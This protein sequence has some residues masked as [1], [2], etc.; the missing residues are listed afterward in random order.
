MRF[1]LK[2]FGL[3]LSASAAVLTLALGALYLGWYHWPGWYLANV[4]P[5]VAVMVGVDVVLGPTLTLII[6]NPGKERRELKRDVAI[7]V[8]VQLAAFT[9][10]GIT[11][12][13]AR[14]LYYAFSENCL[15]LVQASDIDRE[16]ADK[17]RRADLAL[18]PRWMSIPRWIWAPLPDNSAEANKIV[19]AAIAG[20]ADVIDL[21]HYYRPW[22]EG[23]RE[24]KGQLKRVD[25][26]KFFSLAEKH[27]LKDRMRAAG[28]D[29]DRPVGL[30][31][32]GRA[33]PLLAVFDPT[34]LKLLA[35]IRPT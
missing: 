9:Y 4:P 3:H 27:T 12:W 15:S 32:T 1:R 18:A 13:N 10:G 34:N 19:S 7:I 35:L 16:D 31:F 17:A 21:P 5:V 29:P 2:A 23:A 6:A 26:I 30:P 25:D 14:P 33:R 8:A 20:G 11:L 28:L 24:L 22:G